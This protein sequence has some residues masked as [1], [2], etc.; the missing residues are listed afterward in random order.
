MEYFVLFVF[1]FSFSRSE[2]GIIIFSFSQQSILSYFSAKW[3]HGLSFLVG[4]ETAFAISYFPLLLLLLFFSASCLVIYSLTCWPSS[5]FFL[6]SLG[7]QHALI[8]LWLLAIVVQGTERLF[9]YSEQDID[10]SL[11]WSPFTRLR[12]WKISFILAVVISH[13]WNMVGRDS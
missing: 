8:A 11:N 13:S 9:C 1:I 10:V 2:Q 3:W 12:L 6:K 4:R 5:V 7:P